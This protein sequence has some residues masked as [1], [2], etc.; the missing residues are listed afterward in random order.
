MR[1]FIA[2]MPPAEIVEELKGLQKGLLA[3]GARIGAAEQ[4]GWDKEK[5]VLLVRK[6]PWRPS[7]PDQLHLTLQFLGDGINLHQK[8]EIRKALE[9]VGPKHAPFEI[10]PAGLGA[11]PSPARASVLW[12][13]VEGSGLEGLA[14]D[15]EA[16]LLPLDI[17]RDKPFAAHIT[18]ARS[19]LPQDAKAM[20]AHYAGRAWGEKGWKAEEFLLMESTETLGRREHEVVQKYALAPAS[21]NT[22]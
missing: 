11:F 5:E 7:A 1:L 22:F 19:K 21:D 16:A 18:L 2:I 10:R 13:G 17:K 8:E 4:A 15:I 20:L 6:S 14:Q 3:G 9:G 12:A